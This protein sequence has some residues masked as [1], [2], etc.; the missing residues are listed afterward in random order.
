MRAARTL[1]VAL[2]SGLTAAGTMWLLLAPGPGIPAA[3]GCREGAVT[4]QR[5]ELV[6]GL[7]RRGRPD[8]DDGEWQDF[9]SREV[10]PR[11]PDGLTV[12]RADGQWRTAGGDIL[13]E[14]SRLL[15]VWAPPAVDLGPRVEAVRAAW[16]QR[17][18]QES[19]LRADDRQCVSF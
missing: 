19:V 15:L 1:G 10:K 3:E 18:G 9:L 2:A 5:I 6:F 16:K 4:M 8:V 11:F 7:A 17:H 14:P 13:R 12:L